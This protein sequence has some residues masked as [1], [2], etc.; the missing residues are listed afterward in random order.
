M[1]QGWL[2]PKELQAELGRAGYKGVTRVELVEVTRLMQIQIW[3]CVGEAQHKKDGTCQPCRKKAN[4]GH[5][6]STCSETTQTNF[7]LYVSGDPE[8]LS[9]TGIQGDCLQVRVYMLVL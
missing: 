7:S 2:T 9:S 3:L 5:P 4:V 6:S 1:G 8:S